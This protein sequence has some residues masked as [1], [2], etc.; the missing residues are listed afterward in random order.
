MTKGKE[1]DYHKFFK[2]CHGIKPL[3]KEQHEYNCSDSQSQLACVAGVKGGQEEG[4]EVEKKG[5]SPP[6]PLSLSWPTVT[7]VYWLTMF[8]GRW[9]VY[10]YSYFFNFC[11]EATSVERVCHLRFSFSLSLLH[12]PNI[13]PRRDFSRSRLPLVCYV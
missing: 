4:K 9:L 12:S 6:P 2:E 3:T 7:F 13:N 11:V 5:E 8:R 10:F 1:Y